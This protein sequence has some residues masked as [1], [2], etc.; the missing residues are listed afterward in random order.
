MNFDANI[1][2]IFLDEFIFKIESN[3]K[4]HKYPETFNQA[5]LEDAPSR[6]Q[7]SKYKYK[8]QCHSGKTQEGMK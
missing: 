2:D 8:L 7:L 1:L 4:L 6:D 3:S 5:K